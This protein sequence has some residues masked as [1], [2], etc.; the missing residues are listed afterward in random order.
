MNVG[1]LVPVK[2][3]SG[4]CR[5]SGREQRLHRP[6]IE[7]A[8]RVFHADHLVI[9]HQIDVVGCK[10]WRN[11]PNLRAVAALVRPSNLV[12]KEDLLPVAVAQRLTHQHFALAV[13]VVQE[14]SRKLM[15]RSMAER[16]RR[17]RF[18]LLLWNA[19]IW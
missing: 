10:R 6:F 3:R 11:S 18:L 16:I 14:L 19:D 7:E 15:P 2:R 8:V 12:M 17:N 1:V 13:H 5:P 9:L 4:A